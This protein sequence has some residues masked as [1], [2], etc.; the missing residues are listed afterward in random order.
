MTNFILHFSHAL[1]PCAVL[2][3][4]TALTN[5]ESYAYVVNYNASLVP[6]IE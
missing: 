1:Q 3:I 4:C 6:I 5:K 2:F